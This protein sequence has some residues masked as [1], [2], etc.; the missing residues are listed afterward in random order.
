MR[1][2]ILILLASTF[3]TGCTHH[4]LR[5]GTVKQA[6]TLNEVLTRQVL[7]NLAQFSADPY[8]LPHFAIP[9]EGSNQ[10]ADSASFGMAALDTFR[11]ST[12]LGGSRGATQSW[13][14]TPVTNPDRLRRMQC[15]YQKVFG[16]GGDGCSDCCDIEA[17]FLGAGDRTVK[18][19]NLDENDN[20][21]G[22][23]ADRQG[24]P[25][26]D[27][28]SG[29]PFV[30]EFFEPNINPRTGETYE[31]DSATGCVS[32]PEYDCNGPCNVGCGWVN[33]GTRIQI[34]NN[35]RYHTGVFR[36]QAIWVQPCQRDK[37]ARLVLQILDYA[38]S[39]PSPSRT[40]TVELYVGANGEAVAEKEK[41]YGKVTATIPI[42][43]PNHAVLALSECAVVPTDASNELE[44]STEES[45]QALLEFTKTRLKEE[46]E[47]RQLKTAALSEALLA[48][49]QSLSVE[50]IS[51]LAA[52]PK[53]E[54]PDMLIKG[55]APQTTVKN[56]LADLATLDQSIEKDRQTIETQ[57]RVLNKIKEDDSRAFRNIKIPALPKT[58]DSIQPNG[59]ILR[60]SL[61]LEAL[62]GQ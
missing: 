19:V 21:T 17:E 60:D 22:R 40:K 6:G 26:I 9:R 29:Q 2:A 45:A 16:I 58:R 38:T 57:A 62:G 50:T 10:V 59:S 13:V 46:F 18:V 33:R 47:L 32:V 28:L 48:I 34:P 43:T 51:Q 4:Q 37:L 20:V 15:A 56:I 1:I 23:V 30:N 41:A 52:D 44:N 14:L 8:S 54:L 53:R 39:D 11:E 55:D 27:S 61:R 24:R 3:L 49:D 25:L 5:Y 31:I 35:C 12:A 7:D 42:G 36:N